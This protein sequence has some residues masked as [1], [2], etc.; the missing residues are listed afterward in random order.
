MVAWPK[1]TLTDIFQG[2]LNLSVNGKFA[3]LSMR[4]KVYEDK[5]IYF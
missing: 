5:S 1:M 4:I 3:D 2:L